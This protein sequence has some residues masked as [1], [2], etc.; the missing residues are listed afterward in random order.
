MPA[1][2]G[3]DHPAVGVRDDDRRP[4]LVQHR[5]R[6][7]GVLVEARASSSRG[8]GPGAPPTAVL[9]IPLRARSAAVGAR[10]HAPSRENAPWMNTTL[11]PGNVTRTGSYVKNSSRWDVARNPSA[12]PP[13][14][15][16]APTSCSA[17]A[18]L[19]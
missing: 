13:Y 17:T 16:P 4:T 2:L 10:H 7:C 9:T 3:G 8:G 11:T 5:G 15:R 18:C 1:G 12:E 14:W 19:N 6:R